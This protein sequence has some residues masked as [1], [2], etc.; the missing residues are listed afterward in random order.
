MTTLH[1]AWKEESVRGKFK[2]GVSLHGHT[3]NSHEGLGFLPPILKK[4]PTPIPT[5]VEKAKTRYQKK[6]NQEFDYDHGYWTSPISPGMAYDI[7]AGQMD[8]IGLR[9]LISITDHDDIRSYGE[10]VALGHHEIPLSLEWTVPYENAIFHIG[11]HN[12]PP[13]HAE[14]IFAKLRALTADSN[15]EKLAEILRELDSLP[16]T[17]VIL[18]HPLSD[19]GRIGQEIHASV[20]QDF[21]AKNGQWIHALEI[22]AMQSWDIN[23]RVAIIAKDI[24]LPLIAGGD[25]H[26]F[27]PNGIINITNADTFGAFAD[28]I[29]REKKSDIFFMPQYHESLTLR[30]AE[31]VRAMMGRYD[32]LPGHER[33][34][35]RVFYDC[36]DGVTRS[37]T[38]MAAKKHSLLSTVNRVIGVMGFFV[39]YSA[40]ILSPVLASG[41]EEIKV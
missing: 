13:A 17:L 31:N 36:P 41:H 23:R 35:D 34:H 3:W 4:A 33:W 16:N 26:G 14:T 2:T 20:V 27:E 18:N 25:R 28:E 37:F 30:Y 40:V 11:V 29:R 1:Y 15:P 21:L 7:E 32:E 39:D 12:L 22:N 38:E 6:W 5:L 9:P 24:D 10:L 19:Q 8:G